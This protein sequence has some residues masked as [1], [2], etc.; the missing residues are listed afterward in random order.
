MGRCPV[1]GS[2]DGVCKGA[3]PFDETRVVGAALSHP[4]PDDEA[5]RREDAERRRE[6]RRLR[7]ERR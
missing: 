5:A 3:A 1:C 7:R 2:E 6:A 4:D